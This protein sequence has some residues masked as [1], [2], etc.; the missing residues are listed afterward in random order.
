MIG[1]LRYCIGSQSC[2]LCQFK[3]HDY[4]A[5]TIV[6]TIKCHK[7]RNYFVLSL[8]AFISLECINVLV[9]L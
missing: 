5:V 1:E 9:C 4:M 6:Y 3:H 7:K 8:W 2:S